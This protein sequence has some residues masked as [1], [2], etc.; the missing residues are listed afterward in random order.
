MC[1]YIVFIPQTNSN[2]LQV[3]RSR[4]RGTIAFVIIYITFHYN[5][6]AILVFMV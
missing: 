5:F 6:T 4:E 1:M 2:S 3:N